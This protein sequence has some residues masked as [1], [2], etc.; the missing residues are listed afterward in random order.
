MNPRR[1]K[2][3]ALTG[4]T[5]VA[6]WEIFSF[7]YYGSLVPNTAYAKLYT[8]LPFFDGVLQGL[9]YVVDFVLRD[10]AG[11]VALVTCLLVLM[12]RRNDL[13]AR[14]VSAGITLYLLYIVA[15]YAAGLTQ[16]LMW[17]AFD[18]EGYLKYGDFVETTVRLIPM[19]WVR[20][21]GGGTYQQLA[22]WRDTLVEENVIVDCVLGRRGA[23]RQPV[24]DVERVVAG[25]ADTN[26]VRAIR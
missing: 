1:L 14:A 16:G 24:G 12:F 21:I 26:R 15:I 4:T 7:V 2:R 18:D 3:H 17:L 10:P 11:V 13:Q 25:D 23:Q 5:V 20:V 22:E 6:I 19:Y 9:R 8:G